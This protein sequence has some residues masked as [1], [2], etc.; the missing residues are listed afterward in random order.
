MDYTQIIKR[1]IITEKSMKNVSVNQYTFEVDKDATKY[2]I[3]EAVAKLFKVEVY[4]VKVLNR[5]K[6]IKKWRGKPTREL[7]QIA[8]R[9]IVTINPE[10]KIKL[11]EEIGK[12]ELEEK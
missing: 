12:E 6:K 10:Q 11:F 8:R 7:P 3:A 5:R 1:P 4:R 2:Q 9:A